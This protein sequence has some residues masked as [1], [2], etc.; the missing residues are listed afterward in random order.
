MGRPNVGG[1][2]Q[3]AGTDD[4]LAFAALNSSVAVRTFA[5]LVAFDELGVEHGH[6]WARL[7]RRGRARPVGAH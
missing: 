2:P 1:P 4:G 3:A 7:P 6:A 5:P